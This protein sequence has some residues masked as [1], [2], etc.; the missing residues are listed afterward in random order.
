MRSFRDAEGKEDMELSPPDSDLWQRA[1]EYLELP[2]NGSTTPVEGPDDWA[3]GDRSPWFLLKRK[4]KRVIRFK[5]PEPGTAF[6]YEDWKAGRHNDKAVIDI[7]S[8]RKEWE[9]R[10]PPPAKTVI[11]PH[12]P[13]TITLQDTFRKQGLQ[14]IVKMDSVEL[15]PEAPTYSSDSW[16][17]EGQ[18]NEHIVAVAVF[19]YDVENITEPR[20]AFRQYTRL[21]GWF[22]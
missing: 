12:T 13:Y 4:L 15:T 19:A 1:K 22:Y 8:Y 7:V 10:D 3:D 5:H 2:E 14:I 16:Q 20:I 18:L 17:L 9:D 21:H 6:S 11:P